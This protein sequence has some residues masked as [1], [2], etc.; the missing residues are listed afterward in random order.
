MKKFL[1]VVLC[2]G[3]IAMITFS[4]CGYTPDKDSD[5]FR[6]G[7]VYRVISLR[8]EPEHIKNYGLATN[9]M[10]T[11]NECFS[12]I[13]VNVDFGFSNGSVFFS[14]GN[15][16]KEG[17]E[18]VLNSL[19][20][21]DYTL[22]E[23]YDCGITGLYTYNS[24]TNGYPVETFVFHADK[25]PNYTVVGAASD[26]EVYTCDYKDLSVNNG[27]EVNT[28]SFEVIVTGTIYISTFTV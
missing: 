2:A 9:M 6:D 23:K 7:D 21:K 4:G 25:Y 27:A 13:E 18:Q 5:Y 8:G 17:A 15:V 19:G 12:E 28:G 26:V 22:G 10:R 11:V 20:I 3:T 14:G 16:T 24:L 1:S